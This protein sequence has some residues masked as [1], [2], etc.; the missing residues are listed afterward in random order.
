LDVQRLPRRSLAK[1]G[2]AFLT[3]AAQFLDRP[4]NRLRL[5]HHPLPAAEGGVVDHMMLVCGPIAQVYER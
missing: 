5:H 4:K 1:A 2:W 3:L